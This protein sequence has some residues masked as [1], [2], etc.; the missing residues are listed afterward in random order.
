MAS[1][2]IPLAQ[3]FAPAVQEYLTQD[4]RIETD[5]LVQANRL[6][7]ERES[8]MQSHKEQLADIVLKYYVG[9][10]ADDQSRAIVIIKVLFPHQTEGL[11][12]ALARW[13][14]NDTIRAE[15]DVAVAEASGVAEATLQ[16]AQ[17]NE[18]SGFEALASGDIEQA[19][20]HFSAAQAAYP[21]YHNVDEIKQKLDTFSGQGPQARALLFNGIVREN[22]WRMPAEVKGRILQR[23]QD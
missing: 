12:E 13:A 22:A 10:S 19:K 6:A 20:V 4:K 17:A 11:Q 3:V 7:M 16:S 15:A 21:T 9:K 18:Q 8:S 2:F 14:V 1:I 23:A 5:S